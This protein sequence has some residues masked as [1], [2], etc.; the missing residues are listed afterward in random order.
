MLTYLFTFLIS[1]LI[2]SSF[3]SFHNNTVRQANKK[4]K[5]AFDKLTAGRDDF[6]KKNIEKMETDDMGKRK[7]YFYIFELEYFLYFILL[8]YFIF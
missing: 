8:T 3:F 2:V 4:G 7:I 1:S 5:Y 6:D